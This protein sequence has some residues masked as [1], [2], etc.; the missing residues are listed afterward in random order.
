MASDGYYRLP[1]V[2]AP[3][4]GWFHVAMVFHGEG[5]GQSI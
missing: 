2:A 1:T 3:S 5:P 4:G